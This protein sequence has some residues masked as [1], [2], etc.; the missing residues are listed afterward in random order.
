M[1]TQIETAVYS[2]ASIKSSSSSPLFSQ[3]NILVYY[4]Y[5]LPW[6]ARKERKAIE[7][8]PSDNKFITMPLHKL[9]DALT[10]YKPCWKYFSVPLDRPALKHTTISKEN[11]II[12]SEIG[13]RSPLVS[14]RQRFITKWREEVNRAAENLRSQEAIHIVL[15][16]IQTK[17]KTYYSR[18][19]PSWDFPTKIQE[20]RLHKV[21]LFKPGR[22]T[23]HQP[24]LIASS[25][26]R[27]GAHRFLNPSGAV[28]GFYRHH[29]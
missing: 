22:W 6:M 5:L 25:S 11:T 13:V 28:F 10:R 8:H 12:I 24:Y 18:P 9:K 4:W 23:Y 16:E 27:P 1:F 17:T 29:V 15:E 21:Y 2:S 26:P 7:S 14:L 3:K 20:P 19:V